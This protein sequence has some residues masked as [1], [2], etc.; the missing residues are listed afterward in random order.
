M[1]EQHSRV[2]RRVEQQIFRRQR[3]AG[4]ESLHGTGPAQMGVR[5]RQTRHQRC[6]RTIDHPRIIPRQRLFPRARDCGDAIALDSTSPAYGLAPLPSKTRVLTKRIMN[7]S[8][9]DPPAW[10]GSL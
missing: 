5:F 9:R 3:H 4:H 1:I 2:A 8:G 10:R 6:A 7:I